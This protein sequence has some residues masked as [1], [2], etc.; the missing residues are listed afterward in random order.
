MNAPSSNTETAITITF[1]VLSE[2]ERLVATIITPTGRREH[3]IRMAMAVQTSAELTWQ[4]AMDFAKDAGG[5]LPDRVEGALLF[6]TKEDDEFTDD[7]YWTREQYAGDE[8]F[9]WCQYFDDGDQYGFHKG[10]E[11]RVVLVRRVAI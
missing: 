7:W 5:E 3:I 4:A 11:C 10:N 1:P 2:G 8:S 6:Q 9:A